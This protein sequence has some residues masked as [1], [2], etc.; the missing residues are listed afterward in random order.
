MTL[1]SSIVRGL[2]A[3]LAVNRKACR[4]VEAFLPQARVGIFGQYTQAVTNLINETPRKAIVIDIGGGKHCPF[5]HI[6]SGARNTTI[7][8]LDICEGELRQNHD[9]DS[10]LVADIVQAL[11]FRSRTVDLITSR[12]VLEHVVDVTR[13]V[14]HASDVLKLGGY[15]VHLFPSKFAPFAL[16]NQLLPRS[17]SR[18]LVY[19]FRPGSKGILGFP[20]FYDKCYYSAMR[21]LLLKN[22]FELVEAKTSYYQSPYFDFCLPLFAISA[23]YEAL[24]EL[25]GL[26][27]LAAYLLVVARRTR[28]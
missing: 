22:G 21:N 24:I 7:I 18:R 26:R 5:A 17:A 4:R 13:F 9:V 11:P 10:K 25:F 16:I 27:N 20:A 1:R 3:F 23:I 28:A 14:E 2:D 19:F 8:A 15:W 6:A 12:S